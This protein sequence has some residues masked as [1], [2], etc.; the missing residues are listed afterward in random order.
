MYIDR[1]EQNMA[2][3]VLP[4]GE[5]MEVWMLRVF[6]KSVREAEDVVAVPLRAFQHCRD[7]FPIPY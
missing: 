3:M 1:V 4:P 6:E 2:S 5:D 7:G